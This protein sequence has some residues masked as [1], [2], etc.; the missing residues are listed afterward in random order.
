MNDEP[1][2]EKR[3][4]DREF[5][6]LR[7]LATKNFSRFAVAVQHA[8]TEVQ[9]KLIEQLPE[10]KKLAT[11]ALDANDKAFQ[12]SL[13]SNDLSEEGL[14]RAHQQWR[15]ALV[16]MLDDP[17]LT[18]DDKLR[19]TA[20]IAKSVE[21]QSKKDTESKAF[22]AGMFGTVVKGTVL[23]VGVIVLGLAGGKMMMDNNDSEA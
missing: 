23:V 18:L 12:S 3:N 7:K 2:K 1:K 6:S 16:S 15:S 13:K 21:M 10:F 5:G 17:E 14:R 8:S 9:L 4:I 19:I 11:E 20:E 22:K